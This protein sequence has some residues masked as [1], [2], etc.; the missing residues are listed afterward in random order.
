MK[1]KIS[2]K[3]PVHEMYNI[4]EMSCQLNVPSMKCL[5]YIIIKDIRIYNNTRQLYINM[6]PIASQ[7]VGPIGLIFF[8][9]THGWPG[10]VIG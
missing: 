9:G 6:L 2:M 7:T 10:V 5:I 3:C 1:C 8:V 4:Y